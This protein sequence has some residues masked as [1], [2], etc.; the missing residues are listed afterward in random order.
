MELRILSSET[1]ELVE[2]VESTI[3][4]H[5]FGYLRSKKR[6]NFSMRGGRFSTRSSVLSPPLRQAVQSLLQCRRFFL[7]S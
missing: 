3:H 6:T 5:L 4:K 1:V 7:R 2:A